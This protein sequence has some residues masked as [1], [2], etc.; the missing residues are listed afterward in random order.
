MVRMLASAGDYLK[1]QT[2]A[3]TPRRARHLIATGYATSIEAFKATSVV[4]G[5][6]PVATIERPPH[7]A[8]KGARS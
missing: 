7:Q 8:R 4:D 3:M 5:T 6:T 1:G 2:H